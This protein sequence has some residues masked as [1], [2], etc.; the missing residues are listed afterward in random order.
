MLN[1]SLVAA[2]SIPAVCRTTLI[3]ETEQFRPRLSEGEALAAAVRT[4]SQGLAKLHLRHAEGALKLHLANVLELAGSRHGVSTAWNCGGNARALHPKS[5]AAVRESN[6]M[7]FTMRAPMADVTP[8]RRQ[9]KDRR[10]GVLH[11]RA[12]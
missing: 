4:A 6:A 8:G 3:V 10:S 9:Y 2:V 1:D 11:P 12:R 7:S 5:E